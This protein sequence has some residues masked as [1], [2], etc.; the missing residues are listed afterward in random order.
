MI[1]PETPGK[2]I[3]GQN[4]SELAQLA[5]ILT[6]CSAEASFFALF[7]P[8]RCPLPPSLRRVLGTIA[9]AFFC[10]WHYG[11]HEETHE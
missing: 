8:L 4:D 2:M 5:R 9:V 7:V 3:C 6:V 1:L 11:D 10:E